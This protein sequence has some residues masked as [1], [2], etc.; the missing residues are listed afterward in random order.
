MYTGF[1]LPP[2][3]FDDEARTAKTMALRNGVHKVASQPRNAERV[4]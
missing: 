3:P 2:S 4:R 1:G